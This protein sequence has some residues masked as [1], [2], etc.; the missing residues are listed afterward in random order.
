MMFYGVWYEVLT[1]SRSLSSLSRLS[2]SLSIGLSLG[3]LRLLFLLLF[4]LLLLAEERTEEAGALARLRAA[5]GGFVLVLLVFSVLLSRGDLFR[6]GL[7]LLSF[8]L[9]LSG[10]LSGLS[11]SRFS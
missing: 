4:S 2:G 8:L 1:I 9:V 6:L 11:A 5:L 7:L 3:F 10:L